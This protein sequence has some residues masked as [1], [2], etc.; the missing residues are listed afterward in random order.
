[1][2]HIARAA[3]IAIVALATGVAGR[4]V[5]ATSFGS[6][7]QNAEDVLKQVADVP[8]PGGTT[9]FDYQSL[10]EKT[11]KLFISHM[12]DGRLVV[13]DTKT[14]KVV[15]NLPGFNTVTGVRFVPELNRVYASAAGSH[16]VV[17]LDAAS[18]KILARVHGA[19]F[20]DGLAYVPG[21][22]KLYIS[23]ESGGGDLVIDART[24]RRVTMIKLGGEAGNT[25]YDPVSGHVFVTD[26]THNQ[27]VEISPET[28][29][30]VARHEL[31]G[32]SR[33]HGFYIDSARRLMFVSCEGNAKLLVV[34]MR[35]MKVVASETVGRVPDVLAFDAGLKRLYV[36][37][38]SGVVNV[39]DERNGR[40]VRRGEIR[41]PDAHSV[42][43]DPRTRRV[44]LPLKNVG[45]RPVLRIMEPVAGR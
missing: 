38:E 34:D 5:G 43:V 36:A 39:F 9:R 2:A 25:Q 32:S 10:D 12:G 17:A 45:G 23:D 44:Y 26:Q 7:L 11:G 29:K 18:L 37:C 35:T 4:H 15:A 20:P 30:I 3:Q 13:F 1:V 21:V 16:E 33:P 14:N 19:D 22:Q 40:L 27:M 42:S 31:P 8:L 28:D 24:N 41:A 6:P